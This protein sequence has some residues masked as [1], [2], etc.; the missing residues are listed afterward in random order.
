[1]KKQKKKNLS[2]ILVYF[3]DYKYIYILCFFIMLITD[4]GIVIYGAV[5]KRV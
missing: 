5:A 1:M 4:F 3:K 2:K